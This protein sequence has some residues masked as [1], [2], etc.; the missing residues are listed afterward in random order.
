MCL[1]HESWRR[2][3]YDRLTYVQIIYP[4]NEPTEVQ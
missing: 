4:I 1:M 2:E 3:A